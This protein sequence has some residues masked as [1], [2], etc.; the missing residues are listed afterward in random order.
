M[1]AVEIARANAPIRTGNLRYNAIR[2]EYETPDKFTVYVDFYDDGGERSG[3]APYMPFTN[4]PWISP[5]WHG[6]TNP[7]EGWWQRAIEEIRQML[8]VEFGGKPNDNN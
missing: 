1:R 4:E 6:K 3:I 8:Q 2:F 5:K 7:N